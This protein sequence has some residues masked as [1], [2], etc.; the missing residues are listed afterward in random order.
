[1]AAAG[2]R[3]RSVVAHPKLDAR[4][5]ARFSADFACN[6]IAKATT[7]AQFRVLVQPGYFAGYDG[8]LRAIAAATPTAT[9][10]GLG[11]PY[12]PDGRAEQL[13]AARLVRLPDVGH[14]VPIVA[15]ADV[16]AA[17]DGVSA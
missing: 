17:I 3:A 5:L 14:W 8:M 9:V 10:W 13:G 4:Q 6:P 2:S 12:V 7:R 16:V 11:D 15:P 1:V